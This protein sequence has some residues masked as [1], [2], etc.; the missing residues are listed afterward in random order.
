MV[1]AGARWLERGRVQLRRH[2]GEN[3]DRACVAVPPLGRVGAF[4]WEV[5]RKY[6]HDDCFTYA[7]SVSFFLTIS[8]IPLAT[9]VFRLL[10]LMLGSGAY[11][12]ALYRGILEMYPYV[13]Q[14]TP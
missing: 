11:S 6:H 7:A 14:G 3:W 12:Q 5:L 9:L 8:I 4:V 13:P 1:E 10:V 2:A